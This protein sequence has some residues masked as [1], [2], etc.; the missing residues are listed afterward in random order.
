MGAVRFLFDPRGRIGRRQLF[1][2]LFL[3]FLLLAAIV[4]AFDSAALSLA[5]WLASAWPV[6]VATPWKRMH[7][8]GR[9][10]R[11]NLVFYLFYAIG[12][13]FF[14]SEYVSAE[15][16]WGALFDGVPAETTS[17]D[18][19]ASGMGGFSTVLIFLPIQI[20]W[21]YFIPGK[22]GPND[23]GPGSLAQFEE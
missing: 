1:V 14:L 12:F 21:L 7:D 11:W 5:F 19:T 18:L 13:A 2:G 23:Y 17:Q 15:G 4:D 22:R 9:T 16:G 10:G 6:F 3:P 8:M 20:A